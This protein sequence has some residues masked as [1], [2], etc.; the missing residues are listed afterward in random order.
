MIDL[1]K[2]TM[3]T[4]ARIIHIGTVSD[5]GVVSGWYFDCEGKGVGFCVGPNN[6]PLIAGYTVD[7]LRFI[8]AVGD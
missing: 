8:A 4:K 6:E 3:V 2:E 1:R 7:E 5:D